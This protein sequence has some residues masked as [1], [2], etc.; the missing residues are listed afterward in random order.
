M[1]LFW[2]SPPLEA[3]LRTRRAFDKGACPTFNEALHRND[4]LYVKFCEG[5]KVRLRNGGLSDLDTGA[6]A[7]AQQTLESLSDCAWKRGHLLAEDRLAELKARAE[8]RLGRETCDHNLEFRLEVPAGRDLAATLETLNSL[9]CVEIALPI[10]VPRAAPTPPD[11]VGDQV[12]LGDA[13]DGMQVDE[14]HDLPGGLGANTDVADVEYEWNID[15]ADLGFVHQIG[16][17]P[18]PVYGEDHGTAVLGILGSQENGFGTMG[19]V[20]AADLHIVS[21]NNAT[22]GYDVGA[23][24]LAAVNELD[25]GVILL[26]QQ[27]TGPNATGVGQEGLVPVEWYSPWYDA[28]VTA[29]GN[30]FVVVEAAGNGSENLD[31]P[32]YSTGNGGHWPFLA[33]NDSGAIIVGAGGSPAGSCDRS[34]LWFSNYGETVDLQAQGELVVTTGYGHLYSAEGVDFFYTSTF[35]GTSSASAL[36]AGA[37]ALLLSIHE[38]LTGDLLTPAAVLDQL[39]R[40]GSAQLTGCNPTSQN[41]GP[42]PRIVDALADGLP[43]FSRGDANADGSFSGLIDALFLLQYLFAAGTEPPCKDAADANDD[44]ALSVADVLT[45]LNY[46]Y[47][48][49]SPPK[50]PFPACGF[51]PS[52][53]GLGCGVEPSCP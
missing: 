25:D 18:T 22:W 1:T 31:A 15:H 43:A 37:C 21:A 33:A 11:Y 51:D 52:A 35:G 10:P 26:E 45:I 48:V 7:G 53:D 20:P 49:G 5:L 28:I 41:I 46:A 16:P 12:Y 44:G 38:E 30:G 29:V 19:I 36:V 23:A 13:P 3:Q 17:N 27:T 9:Q 40:T 42:R 14:A 8:E 6:L 34:R 39:R 4:A 47:G 50:A 2:L 24:I 32:E